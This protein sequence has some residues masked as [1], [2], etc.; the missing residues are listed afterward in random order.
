[1]PLVDSDGRGGRSY[2]RSPQHH[3]SDP[4]RTSPRAQ[5]IEDLRFEAIN[6]PQLEACDGSINKVQLLERVQAAHGGRKRSR[7]AGVVERKVAQSLQLP[8]GCR[9]WARL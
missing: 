8:D 4:Y 5:D 2:G 3:Q 9:D 6:F 1:M 7:N